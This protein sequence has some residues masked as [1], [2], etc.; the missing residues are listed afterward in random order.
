MDEDPGQKDT[1]STGIQPGD[2]FWKRLFAPDAGVV[3]PL[4][5]LMLHDP[6]RHEPLQSH[7]WNPDSLRTRLEELT[8]ELWSQFSDENL[9]PE[10]PEDLDWSPKVPMTSLFWGAAGTAWA[11]LFLSE[12]GFGRDSSRP[13]PAL[14]KRLTELS[15]RSP[16][17][18]ANAPGY[19]CGRAGIL[20]VQERFAPSPE[21]R[22]ELLHALDETIKRPENELMWGA[23]GA[24]VASRLLYEQTEDDAFLVP[25]RKAARHLLKTWQPDTARNVFTWSQELYGRHSRYLG[26]V[27][28]SMGNAFALLHAGASL[29]D[30]ESELVIERTQDLIER[31]AIREDGLANWPPQTSPDSKASLLQWCHGAPG[32]IMAASALPVG[33]KPTLERTLLEAGELIWKAGPLRKPFGLCHGTAGNGYALLK[34][35]RRTGQE[36]WL[37]HARAFALHALHQSDTQAKI[38]G[39]RRAGLWTGDAGLCFYLW[40]C[41]EGD[42]RWPMLEVS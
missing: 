23:P 19:L 36:V 7:H 34:L 17:T 22:A 12:K 32:V 33:R 1:S 35:F 40:S 4:R 38:H 30:G 11:L 6:S 24:L 18:P 8:T 15:R 31:T 5:C 16:D 39:S 29:T 20:A 21:G 25:L 13:A 3:R 41:L 27:H 37:R 2:D 14:M 28:G 26:P 10:H 9:W 42:D